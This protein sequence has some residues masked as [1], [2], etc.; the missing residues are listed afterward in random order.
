MPNTNTVCRR[1]GPG[2]HPLCTNQSSKEISKKEKTRLRP[3]HGTKHSK[4]EHHRTRP[5][6][7]VR[8][9][10]THIKNKNKNTHCAFLGLN[11]PLRR[12]EYSLVSWTAR[13]TRKT[14]TQTNTRQEPVKNRTSSRQNVDIHTRFFHPLAAAMA[15]AVVGPP[16]LALEARASSRNGSRN[17]LPTPTRTPKWTAICPMPVLI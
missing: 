6:G 13:S 10:R 14:S 4:A 17:S 3:Y 5:R 8:D 2:A 15:A 7:F 9:S 11:S 12:G 1:N 16:T